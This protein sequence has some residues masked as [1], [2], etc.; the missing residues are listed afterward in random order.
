MNLFIKN[1]NL[2]IYPF[3][4]KFVSIPL[5]KISD[6]LQLNLL[7]LT[8]HG[9]PFHSASDWSQANEIGLL[10]KRFMTLY[11]K[12]AFL[13]E[14][15]TDNPRAAYEF[16]FEPAD[17]AQTA[18][19]DIFVG[20]NQNLPGEIPL[21]FVVKPL[22]E[23]C[24][25]TFTSTLADRSNLEFFFRNWLQDEKVDYIQA[26]PYVIQLYDERFRSMEDKSSVIEWMIPVVTR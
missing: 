6:P 10:W 9:D 17:F 4:S 20:F 15:L 16:H 18:H 21:D 26:Y 25:L 8:F 19:L 13:L 22:P 7:G 3:T 5:Y 14:K 12:Y 11:Q 2:F 1:R 23:V 24:Y